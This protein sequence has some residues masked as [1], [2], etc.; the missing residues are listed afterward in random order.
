MHVVGVAQQKKMHVV[1]GSCF[2]DGGLT[3]GHAQMASQICMLRTRVP[4][5]PP[6]SSAPCAVY[7]LARPHDMGACK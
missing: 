4:H 5:A 2:V 3:A 6:L 7:V 1:G